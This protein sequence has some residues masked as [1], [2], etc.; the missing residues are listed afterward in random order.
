MS[1]PYKPKIYHIVHINN[2]ASISQDG[3]LWSD[4]IMRQR[5]NS[6]IIG[7]SNIKDRRLSLPVS[8]NQGTFV[9]EYVPFYFCPRSIM[10]YVIHCKNHA[11]LAY[12]GGQEPIIH[13]EADLM[14]V[15]QS[16]QATGMMW[17]FS[18]SNA[19]AKY[20][21]FRNKT[22]Q[23]NEIK[24]SAVYAQNFRSA[25]V[26]EAKQAEF[27][28]YGSFPWRLVE[29]IGVYDTSIAHQACAVIKGVTHKPS[30]EIKKE[31]YY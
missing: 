10:L 18:L 16:A 14:T 19:A 3:Y 11:E 27:L 9:G 20:T 13:I 23:L 2:L 22:A 31:W 15:I 21:E 8:C 4:A 17:A 5:Q 28:V 29:R 12:T 6:A 26:K 30:V 1:I 24:W 7:M 25:D